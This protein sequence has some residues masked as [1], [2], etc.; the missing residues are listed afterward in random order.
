MGARRGALVL[1]EGDHGPLLPI[2]EEGS[3]RAIVWPGIGATH[4]S[5]HRI[6]LAAASRTTT[7]RHPTEAVYYVIR[8]D[9]A[10]HDPDDGSDGQRLVEGSMIHVEPGTAYRF[11]AGEAG[12][13][14]LGGP[15]PADPTLYEQ[16][17]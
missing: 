5:M 7:L 16:I 13:L 17:G 1:R 2:V 9:G 10:V 14:L 12:I 6:E 11:E 8:G 4:R 3:A 15:C